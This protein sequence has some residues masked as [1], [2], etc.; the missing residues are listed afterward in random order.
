MQGTAK[1]YGNA[2]RERPRS[3]TYQ[4]VRT[5]Y[6]DAIAV[7]MEGRG[8]LQAASA[9]Q[10]VS[11]LIVRGISDLLDDK[12]QSDAAWLAE[13]CGATRECLCLRGVGQVGGTASPL[14]GSVSSTRTVS[15]PEL[16]A[17]ELMPAMPE[18][19]LTEDDTHS[20]DPNDLEFR[21]LEIR[22]SDVLPQLLVHL[23]ETTNFTIE[24]LSE[25]TDRKS[26]FYCNGKPGH[27]IYQIR[28]S[29]NKQGIPI[30]ISV[31]LINTWLHDLVVKWLVHTPVYRG[32]PPCFP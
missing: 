20:L 17:L 5:N 3:A 14:D 15:R 12:E 13:A 9:N 22:L 21:E 7:E 28:I 30:N 24:K 32:I 29:G 10:Q 31:D 27:I 16:G 8:F 26:D 25:D 2:W 11:A 18:S 1:Q 23:Q 4:F 6:S 19:N